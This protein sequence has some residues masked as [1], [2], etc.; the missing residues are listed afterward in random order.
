MKLE[1]VYD[2]G[3]LFLVKIQSFHIHPVVSEKKWLIINYMKS[4]EFQKTQV[5][6]I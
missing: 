5:I 3:I 2:E 4:W 6:R 1:L